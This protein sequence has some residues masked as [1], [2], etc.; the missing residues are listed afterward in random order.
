MEYKIN[1]LKLIKKYYGENMMHLCRELFPTILE[2]PGLLFKLLDNN[3]AHSKFLYDDIVKSDMKVGFKDFVYG[4][5]DE[6]RENPNISKTPYRLLKDA[7]YILYNCKTEEEIQKFRKYY[8]PDEELC[9]F[10]EDRLDYCHV[11]FAVKENVDEIKRENFPIPEREDDYGTS[12]ISIQFTRGDINTLSIKNRYNHTVDNPD[13][14]FSNNL[15]N[16]AIGLTKSFERKYDLNINQNKDGSFKLTGYVLANDGKFYKYNYEIDNVYYCPNNLIIDN[17]K[18]IKDYQEKE[19]YILAD[20]FLIDLVNKEIKF[21]KSDND[22][23]IKTMPVIERID[24]KR[25]KQTGNRVLNI[26]PQEG[27][28]IEIEINKLNQIVG[29]KNNNLKQIGWGFL[30]YNKTLKNIEINNVEKIDSAFLRDNED[31]ETIYLPKVVEVGAHCLR[32]NRVLRKADFPVLKKAGSYFMT[33]A[34]QLVVINAPKIR[35][36]GS[37]CLQNNV[38]LIRIDFPELEIIKDNF[39]FDNQILEIFN[40]PKVRKIGDSCLIKNNRIK[41][42]ILPELMVVGDN[43]MIFNIVCKKTYFPKLMQTGIH[44]LLNNSFINNE[45]NNV[46]VKKLKK[47]N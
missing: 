46:L 20:N 35:V 30:R 37:N 7:G 25:D 12:V 21:Y 39:L 22:A 36:F 16:I 3:F 31:M 23:F 6:K 19:K 38:S 44:F 47:A 5:T 43:F 32:N 40:C 10:N 14:T 11:F 27:S 29:Y 4:L 9:T 45:N 33:N 17:F 34:E 1:D 8:E 18:V 15:E 41:E 13:A 28:I 2:T 42:L 26:T 24:I